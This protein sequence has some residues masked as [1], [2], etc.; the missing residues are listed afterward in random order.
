MNDNDFLEAKKQY[1]I[2]HEHYVRALELGPEMQE[3]VNTSLLYNYQLRYDDG[4]RQY[5]QA[6]NAEGDSKADFYEAAE[7]Q[8]RLA[9]AANPDSVAP[10][11]NIARM[12]IQL[13]GEVAEEDRD[14]LYGES[15]DLLDHVLEGNPDAFG[16]LSDKANVLTRL[17]RGDEA[18]RIYDDL[19]VQHPNDTGLLIDIARLAS[20]QQDF[21][22]AADLYVKV[23]G[24]YRD[25]EIV[26]NDEDMLNLHLQAGRFYGHDSVLDYRAAI[27]NYD[28]AMDL[29]DIVQ[30]DTLLQKLRSH[31]L[32][33]LALAR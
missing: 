23:A 8:F 26:E 17:G 24:I 20:E 22:R 11:K 6:R 4:T 30:E 31:Y 14:R 12:K 2:A 33:G 21:K 25:D 18:N 1:T 7:G 10:I 28:A 29:E 32:Y 9:Y 3:K 15:L 16:L 13:A 5:N 27:E 19:I